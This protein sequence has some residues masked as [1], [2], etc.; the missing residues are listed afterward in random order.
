MRYSILL[1]KSSGG[2]KVGT[3]TTLEEAICVCHG[4]SQIHN[5]ACVIYDNDLRTDDVKRMIYEELCG[6]TYII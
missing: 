4:M 3:A 5:T 1:P 2:Y 6:E